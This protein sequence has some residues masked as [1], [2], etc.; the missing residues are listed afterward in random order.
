[1]A[2]GDAGVDPGDLAV[3]HQLG[4]FQGLLDT[5]DRGVDVDDH[6]ALEAMAGGHAQAR[7]PELAARHDFAHHHHHLG[8]SDVEPD[9]QVFVLFCHVSTCSL[10]SSFSACVWSA[11]AW[12]FP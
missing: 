7:Q 5:V 4:L 10:S 12:P 11:A 9:D 6:A 1:M 8:G 3:G 2:A